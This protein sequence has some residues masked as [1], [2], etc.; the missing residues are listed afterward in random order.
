MA[1]TRKL[2]SVSKFSCTEEW[3]IFS[4]NKKLNIRPKEYWNCREITTLFWLQTLCIELP[5]TATENVVKSRTFRERAR[6]RPSPAEGNSQG[7]ARSKNKGGGR[8]LAN[9]EEKDAALWRWHTTQ[10]IWR[11]I[12]I[13]PTYCRPGRI[14]SC[15]MFRIRSFA[16]RA[17]FRLGRS[18]EKEL[19]I[20]G[21]CGDGEFGEVSIVSVT[22]NG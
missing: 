21:G 7:R 20:T 19:S 6:M 10:C 3:I 18:L 9:Q 16:A 8:S 5:N 14:Y 15:A 17:A 13:F 4:N 11:E 22:S 1:D 12:E 2:T